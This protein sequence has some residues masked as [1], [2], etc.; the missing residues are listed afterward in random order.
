MNIIPWGGP[1]ARAMVSLGAESSELFN[2]IIPA[3]LAGAVWVVFVSYIFGKKERKRIGMI[4]ISNKGD[5]MESGRNRGNT[6]NVI[7]FTETLLVQLNLNYL[8]DCGFNN[9][10]NTSSRLIHCCIRNCF[11][12]EL[13]R[14]EK[15]ARTDCFF[16]MPQSM[17]MVCTHH[18]RGWY[19]HRNSFWH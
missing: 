2:P 17:V 15:T 11:I 3:M 12:S 18:I 1:L 13:S 14:R 4:K 6:R 19:F 16:L 5:S 10:N 8:L 7:K 9:G